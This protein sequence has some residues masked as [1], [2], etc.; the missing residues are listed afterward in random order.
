MTKRRGVV[1]KLSEEERAAGRLHGL[2][3]ADLVLTFTRKG[4]E[5]SG[6]FDTNVSIG[7]T[8]LIP[9][10]TVAQWKEEVGRPTGF[11]S[12]LAAPRM[13]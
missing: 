1:W 3:T 11:P 7:P 2:T 8:W 6:Y 4:I 13:E 5:V 12:C 9:W 10:R